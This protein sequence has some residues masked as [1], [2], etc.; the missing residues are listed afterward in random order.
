MKNN[1]DKFTE[2][3]GGTIIHP[4]FIILSYTRLAIKEVF[5][6]STN[7]KL[8]DIGAGNM[9]YRKL[10]ET[11]LNQYVAVDHPKISRLYNPD[12]KPDIF[13]DITKKIPVKN[14]TFDIAIMLE[15]LEYLE[16]PSQTFSEIYRILKNGGILIFTTPFLYSLHDLPYDRNRFTE[17]QIKSFLQS[18]NLKLKKVQTN[19]T[20]LSFWFQS[21]NV[22][23]LKRIMDILK[24]KINLYSIIYLF[25]LLVITPEI[26]IITN[27]IFLITKNIKSNFPN[28]FP[29][30]YL[31]VAVKQSKN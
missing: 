17:T 4:Q 26:V 9:P 25:L 29:L 3:F 21:L 19:G 11:K 20:F 13:A 6:Y 28:Y 1:W 5:K 24:S 16:N 14:N 23:L 18:S 7:K 8:I 15:V 22:F 12:N 27:I 2:K 30:D 10:L 31:V